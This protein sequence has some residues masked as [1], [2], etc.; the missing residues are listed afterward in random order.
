[1][2][3]GSVEAQL[4]M[5]ME[6]EI[7]STGWGGTGLEIEAGLRS[8]DRESPFP[9][10]ANR[11]LVTALATLHFAPTR[12]NA[13]TLRSEGVPDDRIVET[14]NPVVDAV[15]LIRGS[16]PPSPRVR[17]LLGRVSGQRLIVMTTHRRESF[18]AVMRERLR[19]IRRFV[20]ANEDVAL[21]FPVHANPAVAETAARELGGRPR[22]HLVA[23]LDYP[24]FLHAMSSAWLILSDSGGVQEEAPSLGKPLLVMRPDTERPEAIE[25]GVARLV[26][27]RAE[28][29][30]AA[31]EEAHRP[32]SWA[33]RV[34]ATANPFGRGDSAARI[35]DAILAWG[36]AGAR[37]RRDRIVA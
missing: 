34:R 17:D 12:R 3:M 26:G 31:L 29:L 18:G 15:N 28:A 23:P 21:I 9:E 5:G 13:E 35:A 22:I 6:G 33:S 32:G 27:D 11:R 14:G 4:A 30:R 36:E 1:M 37:G 10:E 20:E 16:Q 2:A 24:D 8:G 7:F 19:V 25:C